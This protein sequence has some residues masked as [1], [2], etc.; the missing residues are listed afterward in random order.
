MLNANISKLAHTLVNYSCRLQ[1][2]EKV[3]IEC[4]GLE[5]PL[6]QALVRDIYNAG[7][8]PFVSIKDRAV[9]RAILMQASAEQLKMAASYEARRMQD[10]NAYIGIRSG[11][12]AF[13]L[14]DVSSRQME[15]YQ[16]YFFEEVHSKI[17]VPSTKWV[18]LRYPTPSMA[19]SAAMS[20]EAFADYFFKVCT[21]DYSRLSQA[22]EP[23]IERLNQADSVRIVGPGTD[24][25]FSI[26]GLKAVKC[27]GHR[28]I[29]DGEVYTAPVKDSVNGHITYNTPAL[30]QGISFENIRFDFKQGKIIQ[31]TS[32]HTDRLNQ[33]LDTDAGARY[34][35]EFSFG[36]NPF[37]TQPI[38]D[39][40]FDE[41]IT[42]SIHFTPG[43]CYDECSNGNQSAIHWDL[44][45]IQTPAY[46]GG[47][48]Y[49][50][51]VLIRKDGRFVLP[52]LQVLNPENL[53]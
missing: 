17:R 46:G 11:N 4:T 6:I 28:N 29:P 19:Q 20:T 50:D 53:I 36:L 15:M 16:K 39:T 43:N 25:S 1:P 24:L 9:E 13:E 31:A 45:L 8:L 10:M 48:I 22:M 26:A 47:E 3:L 34:I 40:L 2:G 51:E 37:I 35:G 52:E 32:N 18:V 21:L 14:A 33:I 44:V 42:G 41:K 38:L 23:L 49:V 27:D 7:G 5:L 30:Y 12:N